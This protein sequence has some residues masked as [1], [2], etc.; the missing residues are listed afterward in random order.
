[1]ASPTTLGAIV[2]KFAGD[3][4]LAAD[5]ADTG[6]LWVCE[7]PE[8]L[9]SFPLVVLVQ[10]EEVPEWDTEADTITEIGKYEFH[11]FHTSLATAESIAGHVKAVFDPTSALGA[12]NF[13]ALDVTGQRSSWIERENYLVRMAEFRAPDGKTVFEIVLPFKSVVN[14]AI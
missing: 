11:I 2:A 4:T 13:P 14:K 7:V 5:A 10:I 3:A 8:Q 1:M 9:K 6:G 12:G